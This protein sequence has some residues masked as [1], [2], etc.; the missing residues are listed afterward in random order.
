[1]GTLTKPKPRARVAVREAGGDNEVER[2]GLGR[3]RI[4]V[5]CDVCERTGKVPSAKVEGRL[6]KCQRCKGEG[7]RKLSY[8]R[9]TTF[10]DCL[11]DKEALMAWMGRM[12]LLGIAMD[13]G[14]LKGVLDG[15]PAEKE[16]KDTLNR[17]AEAAK[18][19]A[20]ANDKADKGTFLHGL[21]ELVDVGDELPVDLDVDDFL[22]ITSYRDATEPLLHIVLM[23]QLMVN[24][25][26]RTA[27][28]P[29]RVS[30]VRDGVTL[31][32]PDGYV[33][34][35]DE[36]IITDLKTG[37]VD[38]GRL[39]MAMQLAL[40]SRSKRYNKATGERIE[41]PGINQDWGIIMHTAAGSNET[42]LYWANLQMGWTAVSL[43]KEVRSA[44]SSSSKALIPFLSTE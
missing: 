37:R 29:D 31:T 30:R 24:D 2:D 6:N 20:G 12:V 17:R 4:L 38:Y 35:P 27:G 13:T 19:L 33:F 3:P 32:A 34:S 36:L 21:S 41:V 15:D 42:H 16:V 22:D 44:R 43:A 28:T 5:D 18:E 39:K 7:R 1:M 11:E 9:V 25:E 10:I 40:Y 14:F 26:Y 23:E 8:T